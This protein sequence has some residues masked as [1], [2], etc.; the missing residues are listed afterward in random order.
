MSLTKKAIAE[1]IGT[2]WLVFRR[3]RQCGSRGRLP[4][5]RHRVRRSRSGIWTHRPDHG[6][7][8]RSHFRVSLKSC[9]FSWTPD[10]RAV[11]GSGFAGVRGGASPRWHS[12]R[13][14]ALRH[15]Q[16]RRRLHPRG[17]LRIERVWRP[18]ARALQHDR[19]PGSRSRAHMLLPPVILGATDRRA[20]AGFAGI[21]IGLSLTLIHLIGIPVTNLSVNPARSTGPAVFVGGWAVEQLWLFWLAPI[22]G[23]AIAGVVYKAVFEAE[24]AA[25]A[26]AASASAR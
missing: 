16:R 24:E 7:C 23:A 19:V 22:V 21:A 10:G 12:G 5:P 15:C 11:Q 9:C 4:G 18:L 26:R 13:R 17:R 2:F 1:F 25:P 20:P 14:R 6:L 3:L 8:H